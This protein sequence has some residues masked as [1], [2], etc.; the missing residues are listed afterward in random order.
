MSWVSLGMVVVRFG[1]PGPK[2]RAWEAML[3]PPLLHGRGP[4]P[5]SPSLLASAPDA[6]VRADAHPP[7]HSLHLLLLCWCG[8]MLAPPYSLHWLLSR[9]CGQMPLTPCICYTA[10]LLLRGASRCVGLSAQPRSSRAHTHTHMRP[11]QGLGGG[12]DGRFQV[13]ATAS[14][15]L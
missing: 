14:P 1:P 9:W 13:L 2:K 8:Q 15:I 11:E 4:P 12:F 6:L 10:R 3:K 7:P 5:L